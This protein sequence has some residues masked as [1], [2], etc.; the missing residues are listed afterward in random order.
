MTALRDGAAVVAV[1]VWVDGQPRVV[2]TPA[3]VL[4]EALELV[5]ALR[6]EQ[7]PAESETAGGAS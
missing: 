4:A 6:T 7:R 5:A 1:R 3:R 2:V